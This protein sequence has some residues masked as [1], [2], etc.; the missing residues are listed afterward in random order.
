MKVLVTTYQPLVKNNLLE[1]IHISY[2]TK[3]RYNFCCMSEMADPL[4]KGLKSV[5]W[6]ASEIEKLP[7]ASTFD[8]IRISSLIESILSFALTGTKSWSLLYVWSTNLEVLICR[9][10]EFKW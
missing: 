7:P 8:S 4:F 5:L 1:R 10:F 3:L 9:D 6:T 2:Q